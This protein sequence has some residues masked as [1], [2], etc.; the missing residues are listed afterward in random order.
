MR[1]PC[2]CGISF[3]ADGTAATCPVCAN[4]IT[5]ATD[6]PGTRPMCPEC[7]EPLASIDATCDTCHP[8]P[9]DEVLE[10]VAWED[11]SRPL[12][13]RWWK[14]FWSFE[15]VPARGSLRQ[16]FLFVLFTQFLVWSVASV[17]LLVLTSTTGKDSLAWMFLILAVAL[18]LLFT[19][20]TITLVLWTGVLH[21]VLRRFGGVGDFG[22]TWRCCCYCMSMFFI[23]GTSW[24]IRGGMAF[25][26]L[27]YSTF[28]LCRAHRISWGRTFLAG[29]LPAC[30]LLGPTVLKPL[31]GI[32][33]SRMRDAGIL[34][35]APTMPR[36]IPDKS[37]TA[38]QRT[39]LRDMRAIATKG[40]DAIRAAI[41]AADGA[42]LKRERDAIVAACDRAAA[43]VPESPESHYWRA[44]T[45]RLCGE[46][47]LNLP[48]LTRVPKT[49]DIYVP[50]ALEIVFHEAAMRRS[51]RRGR[52]DAAIRHFH[53][54][55]ARDASDGLAGASAQPPILRD[56]VAPPDEVRRLKRLVGEKRL[57]RR[58]RRARRRGIVRG[59]GDRR[60]ARPRVRQLRGRAQP[61]RGGPAS[62]RRPRRPS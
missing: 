58:P 56:L 7:G 22:A 28:S 47:G 4:R 8:P 3:E 11:G 19:V 37:L 55:R 15:T 49:D 41:T 20:T 57:R 23:P 54:A 38:D 31:I 13:K 34:D 50:H 16:P 53:F 51:D 25:G 17:L 6:S 24:W 40:H 26:I 62:F 43:A 5:I 52:L 45:L 27:L 61:G 10:Y 44:R 29:L 2:S 9:D 12:L 60:H 35:L 48:G 14:T 32:A 21:F 33:T 18:P 36:S 42:A 39:A 46:D 1:V 59:R 30:V